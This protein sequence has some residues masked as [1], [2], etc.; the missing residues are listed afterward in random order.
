[1]EKL[2]ERE[3]ATRNPLVAAPALA[4]QFFLI[5][6]AVVAVTVSV[7]VGFRSL[8][9]DA[10]TPQDYLAEVQNGGSDRRWP[11]AY[12]LSRLMADPKV[13]ADRSLAPS[14]VKA[15]R[16]AKDDAQVR[17]YLAL[18]IGRLDPP[19]PPDAVSEL[20]KALDD[21]DGDTRISV[22]WALGSSGDPAVVPQL[23]S[24]YT[25]PGSD[26]GV[27]K[28]VIYALGALPGTAQMDALRTGLQDST[29]DVRWNAAVALAR[30]GS[31]DG[32]SVLKQMLDRT[33]VEQTVKRTVRQDEDE[34][35][36]ADVMIGGLRAAATLKDESL[37]PSVT[38][39]SQNDRS[40]R[41][42][43]AALEALKVMG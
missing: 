6:L 36:V 13:R 42:R 23:I 28:I 32:V 16:D 17:R 30:H 37:R 7:Y 25:S 31:T 38:T 9:A 43:E 22:I 10:R 1:M 5:P 20:T 33:Y 35:P 14:L 15:F 40:I 3:T 19:L 39:L 8:L 11:A 26:A 27:R 34:D 41:V 18:A 24:L 4:V 29:P 21:A 12:E 2:S